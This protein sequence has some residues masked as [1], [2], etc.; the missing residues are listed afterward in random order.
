[1]SVV[2]LTSALSPKV[3]GGRINATHAKNTPTN[4]AANTQRSP[5][6]KLFN[7]IAKTKLVKNIAI[8]YTGIPVFKINVWSVRPKI[9]MLNSVINT[10]FSKASLIFWSI[11]LQLK[12]IYFQI[13]SFYPQGRGQGV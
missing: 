10:S 8:K 1:M 13:L 4:M 7:A 3:N 6:F 9:E 2:K 5:S 12:L 11:P